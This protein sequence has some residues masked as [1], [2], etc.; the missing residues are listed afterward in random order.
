[1][2]DRHEDPLEELVAAFR[3]MPVPE[4]PDPELMFSRPTAHCAMGETAGTDPSRIPWRFLMRPI[5]RYGSAAPMLIVAAGWLAL[6]PTR[7][8]A[9]AEVIRAAEQHKR[10][11]FSYM[12]GS[13]VPLSSTSGIRHAAKF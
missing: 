4:A 12:K 8:F 9:L 1:M 7:S 13:A 10:V 2:T 3:R 5:V 6:A 11:A